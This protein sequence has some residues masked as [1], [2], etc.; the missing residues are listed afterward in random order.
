MQLPPVFIKNIPQERGIALI[1]ALIS[2]L[3]IMLSV[4]ASLYVVSRANV[5]KTEMSM[6]SIAT[7]EMRK[8]LKDGNPCAANLTL[9]L[10]GVSGA[11]PVISATGCGVPSDADAVT[12]AGSV[13]KNSAEENMAGHIVLTAKNDGASKVL[14]GWITVGGPAPS[15]D[16]GT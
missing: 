11:Q 4:A 5:A 2:M 14:A 13:V 12:V 3:I 7:E 6:Q 1:E 9:H 8:L 15:E 16:G 10:P